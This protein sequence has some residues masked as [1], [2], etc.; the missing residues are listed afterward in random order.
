MKLLFVSDSFKGSLTSDQTAELLGQAAERV[1]GPCEHAGVPVADG[2]EGTTDAVVR[3]VGGALRTVSA[4][5]PLM[6]PLEASY[7]MLDEHRALVEM[8]AA[9]GLPL[10]PEDQ[11]N[12]LHTSTFGTGEL[13]RDALDHGVDE[14]T[15]GL[16]GS[17]TNDGGMGCLRALG[18]RFL[19]AQGEELAGTGADLERVAHIDLTDLHPRAHEVR[20]VAM[21]DV[22]NPLCG[23]DGATHTFGP[24]KGATPELVKRLEQGMTNYRDVIVRELGVDP[25]GIPGAGAA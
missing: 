25:D 23:P 19:D 1:F 8:A 9:S 18:V 15:V 2:G 22:D 10:V 21:C 12:P 24:Q 4:H 13:I 6:E 20:F 7:G 11:R 17:A 5:G 14:L 3:A 16:G